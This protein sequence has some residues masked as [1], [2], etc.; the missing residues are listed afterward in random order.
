MEIF[1]QELIRS[2]QVG[3][4]LPQIVEFSKKDL[5]GALILKNLIISMTRYALNARISTEQAKKELQNLCFAP[6][7][8]MSV[9]L[10]VYF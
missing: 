6:G 4:F 10:L 5:V 3:K 8:Y 2:N 1:S 7:T 9:F